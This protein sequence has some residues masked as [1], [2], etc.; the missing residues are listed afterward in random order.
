MK[1]S[2][3]SHHKFNKSVSSCLI[4]ELVWEI[5]RINGVLP[6]SLNQRQNKLLCYQ[7]D[8][9]VHKVLTVLFWCITH[10]LK[11]RADKYEQ[12]FDDITKNIYHAIPQHIEIDV[13]AFDHFIKIMEDMPEI[14]CALIKCGFPDNI[15]SL[16]QKGYDPKMITSY[17]KC[18]CTE[19]RHCDIFDKTGTSAYVHD[20]DQFE[21]FCDEIANY[22]DSF[23]DE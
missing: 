22:V 11:V 19:C 8:K 10:G 15:F 6:I 12:L 17:T 14:K 13:D 2:Y 5:W 3:K 9:P 1:W 7:R 16:A 21:N 23:T 20:K 18:L 4:R